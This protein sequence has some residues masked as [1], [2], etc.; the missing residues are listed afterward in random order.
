M[1]ACSSTEE[2]KGTVDPPVKRTVSDAEPV[3]KAVITK[4]GV[5]SGATKLVSEFEKK[6]EIASAAAAETE[7]KPTPKTKTA[8]KASKTKSETA[9]ATQDLKT[10]AK[11]DSKQEATPKKASKAAAAGAPVT[12]RNSKLSAAAVEF[13][14]GGDAAS[15]VTVTEEDV[16]N[17]GRLTEK[18]KKTLRVVAALKRENATLQEQ[19]A[20][21]SEARDKARA[22]CRQVMGFGLAQCGEGG[23]APMSNRERDELSVYFVLAMAENTV[24]KPQLARSSSNSNPEP[25]SSSKKK[26][27]RKRK[28]R[29]DIAMAKAS[30]T[31]PTNKTKTEAKATPAAAAKT[32]STPTKDKK[33]TRLASHGSAN[34]HNL[35]LAIAPST[36]AKVKAKEP[37]EAEWG[38]PTASTPERTE[39]TELGPMTTSQNTPTQ[40][41]THNDY[42]FWKPDVA[43]EAELSDL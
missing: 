15:T 8:E 23:N 35:K 38:G 11:K 3:T 42:N 22:R 14:M 19:L 27:Q 10:A 24:N 43:D 37:T 40:T 41:P 5:T 25:N 1:G 21:A 29:K 39:A 36:P 31:S 28:S 18:E 2:P 9:K 30:A 13:K 6:V 26:K 33:P 12:P 17:T 20:M 34:K 16:C 7:V 32:S 4:P